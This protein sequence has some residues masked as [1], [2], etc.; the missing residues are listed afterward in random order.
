MTV[1]PGFRAVV[2]ALRDLP[3]GDKKYIA[4][5]ARALRW[6][7]EREPALWDTPLLLGRQSD[8]PPVPGLRTD[9]EVA[10]SGASVLLLAMRLLLADALQWPEL[11]FLGIDLY[12]DAPDYLLFAA[13]PERFTPE[14]LADALTRGA[15]GAGTTAATAT[16]W[17]IQ[18]GLQAR[19]ARLPPVPAD[20]VPVLGL[21]VP[22]LG[23]QLT[24]LRDLRPLA[25]RRRA[26]LALSGEPRVELPAGTPSVPP[27]A[28]AGHHQGAYSLF[29]LLEQCSPAEPESAEAQVE[30][31]LYR[32]EATSATAVRLP[33]RLHVRDLSPL[34]D[35]EAGPLTPAVLSDW[36]TE[37]LPSCFLVAP[38]GAVLLIDWFRLQLGL[39]A[40]STGAAPELPLQLCGPPDL[41][42]DAEE[43]DGEALDP[44]L[45]DPYLWSLPVLADRIAA[46]ELTLSA[47]GRYLLLES[48]APLDGELVHLTALFDLHS[49][50]GPR[51]LRCD[52][53]DQE[54]SLPVPPTADAFPVLR[55]E[56]AAPG[57]I[58]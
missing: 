21:Q 32:V 35:A 42:S 14:S 49:S 51:L 7:P 6:A 24:N 11:R 15:A 38:T 36:L 20:R 41:L 45:L 12:K 3:P 43:T 17:Q 50:P 58:A 22:M 46:A 1:A 30:L 26:P 4:D 33:V 57:A 2:F 56:H 31:M 5:L 18:R 44:I 47:S 16:G 53:Q 48:A 23:G 9:A 55:G 37:L 40:G 10:A 54:G 29:L 39:S 28:V 52:L 19:P 8:P 34:H 27:E 25:E 13:D